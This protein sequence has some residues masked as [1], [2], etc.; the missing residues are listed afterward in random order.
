MVRRTSV[1]WVLGAYVLVAGA[2]E[3]RAQIDA[4]AL[5]RA[6]APSVCVVVVEG[7]LG[8]PISYASGFLMGQGK[9][10]V[11]DL[12]SVAQPGAAKVT[13][14]FSDGATARAVTFGMADAATGLVALRTDADQADREGL[15]LRSDPVGNDGLEAA[16]VGWQWGESLS[17]TQGRVVPGSSAADLAKAVGCQ[18]PAGAREFLTFLCPRCEL[19]TG[20][21]VVGPE[22]TVVGVLLQVVGPEKPVVVPTAHIRQALLA[23][24]TKLR[25]VN[26]LPGAVWPTDVVV[27]A[28]QPPTPASFA[29]AVR[30]VKRRSVCAKCKGTGKIWVRRFVGTRKVFNRTQRI[31]RKEQ[32]RCSTCKGEGIVFPSDLYKQFGDMAQG[33]TTLISAP[34]T[35]VNVRKAALNNSM[36]LLDALSQVSKSYRESLVRGAAADLRRKGT[37]C[38]RGFLTHAQVAETVRLRGDVFTVLCPSDAS[39]P[40]IVNADMLSGYYGPKGGTDSPSAKRGQWTVTGGTL[41]GPV[42]IQ[43]QRLIFAR[44]FG[45]AGG[46]SMGSAAQRKPLTNEGAK[47]MHVASAKPSKPTKPR[48]AA[49]KPPSAGLPPGERVLPGVEPAAPAPRTRPRPPRP[50]REKRPGEPSFFGL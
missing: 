16:A 39:I 14:R 47:P 48:P 17:V 6:A 23:A 5:Q 45:W 33:A 32:E 8:L 19:A 28:G 31:Y 50:V 15:A 44:L 36:G 30:L 7:P 13:V 24:G 11:T 40:L 4:Q 29:A 42:T 18:A 46:P 27:R 41:V 12:A 26:A 20:A 22:G 37:A 35:P 43:G 9:F 38:P 3:A 1:C 21:P 25:P 34:G 10:V 49:P 2:L